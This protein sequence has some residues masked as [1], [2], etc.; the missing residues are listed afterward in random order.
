MLYQLLL[1]LAAFIAS[2][3]L[4]DLSLQFVFFDGVVELFRAFVV[5]NSFG[6]PYF[7]F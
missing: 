5:F 4:L 2:L 6:L 1:S 3:K 7:Y